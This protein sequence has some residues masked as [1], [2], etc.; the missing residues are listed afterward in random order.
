MS[1]PSLV[2]MI[3][4][5]PIS[6][7]GA[8]S[9]AG[10]G[11]G[12]VVFAVVVEVVAVRLG[13]VRLPGLALGTSEGAAVSGIASAVLESSFL[14]VPSVAVVSETFGFTVDV[15]VVRRPA[16]RRVR[17][18]VAAVVGFAFAV[19][20]SGWTSGAASLFSGV[21]SGV[22]AGAAATSVTGGSGSGSRAPT[23]DTRLVFPDPLEADA[24]GVAASFSARSLPA[25]MG[26]KE[27]PKNN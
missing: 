1:V 18:V 16:G 5:G 15:V 26:S 10:S 14:A 23:D 27:P 21:A 4:R 25:T 6:G 17:G 8:T 13:F 11:F 7:S 22:G 9:A 12:F 3:R 19:G 20:A 2:S 24:S